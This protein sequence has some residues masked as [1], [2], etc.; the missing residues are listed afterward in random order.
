MEIDLRSRL[1]A[2]ATV[3]GERW[4]W[5]ERPSA[6]GLPAGVL[7]VVAA[8]LAYTLKGAQ[9]WQELRVRA[10]LYS[11]SYPA[12]LTFKDETIAAIEAP[13]TQG[14][15]TFSPAFVNAD[16]DMPSETLSGGGRAFRRMIDFSIW[17]R[18]A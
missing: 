18:P 7:S 3:A 12:L 10:N 16:Q 6:D 9:R 1:V 2:A 5:I 15:T 13:A 8:P 11:A 14:G 4:S 17:H